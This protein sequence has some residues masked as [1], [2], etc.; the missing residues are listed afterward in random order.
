MLKQ[1]DKP[2]EYHLIQ[3]DYGHDSFL[4]EPEKFTPYVVQFLE[5]QA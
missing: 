4:I 2:V 1:L 5:R 3:S